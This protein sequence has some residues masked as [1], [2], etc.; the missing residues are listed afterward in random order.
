MTYSEKSGP[1]GKLNG[2]SLFSCARVQTRFLAFLTVISTFK[3]D[4]L[5]LSYLQIRFFMQ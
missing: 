1:I 5:T 2:F 3:I 4:S